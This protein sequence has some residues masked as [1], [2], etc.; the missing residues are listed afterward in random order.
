[1]R[2]SF[3]M[4]TIPP[5][6][7]LGPNLPTPPPLPS[8]PLLD[9]LLFEQPFLLAGLLAGLAL[10]ALFTYNARAQLKWG[11][12]TAVSLLAAGVIAW[13]VST[14]VTTPRETIRANT[15]SLVNAVGRA[16]V[17]AIDP[18]LTHDIEIRY[19]T[20]GSP[21]KAALLDRIAEAMGEG[22][23][24]RL[25]SW[26]IAELQATLDGPAAARAQVLVRATHDSGVPASAWVLMVWKRQPDM[27][28]RCSSVRP[29]DIE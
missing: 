23:V 3:A 18:L 28:W 17:A 9:T 6:L 15:R 2:Q 7:G 19:P 24:Y 25:Q 10:V 4:R 26:R 11:L 5:G 1:M 27:T 22:G 13:A 8:P 21:S 12:I 14:L 16:D 29:I 20:F